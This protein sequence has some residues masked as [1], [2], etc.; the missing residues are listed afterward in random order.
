MRPIT[1]LRVRFAILAG[2][3]MLLM[4]EAGI[5]VFCKRT[6]LLWNAPVPV[7]QT[8]APYLPGNPYLLWEMVPGERE[9]MGATVKVNKLGFRGPETPIH[10]PSGTKRILIV[11]DS[12]VYGHGVSNEQTFGHLL[13]Q[14]LPSDFEVLNLGAPGYSTEQTLN[15]M[16]MRGWQ[17]S[18]DLLIVAN[19][20]SDN[21]FD[22]FIDKQLISDRT[23]FQESWAAP[24]SEALQHSALYRWLDWNLRLG[25]KAAE[26]QKVGWMLGRAPSGVHRRVD[27]NDYA[28]NLQT[29]VDKAHAQ[30]CHVMFLGLANAVD[31]G[32]NTEGAIAWPLYREVMMDTAK[33]NGAP[34]ADVASHFRE[35]GLPTSSLFLDEM[36]PS[37]EGHALISSLLETAV[38]PWIDGDDFELTA[39]GGAPKRWDDPFSRGEGPP[40]DDTPIAK[41]TLSGK[42]IGAPE[43]IPIQIDLVN[44]DPERDEHANPMLG[45]ARFD[46]VDS[47][48]MPAPSSGIFGLRL[49]LDKE[50]DGPTRGDPM[51]T[52]YDHPIRA[53]GNSIRGVVIDM[54]TEKIKIPTR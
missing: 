39:E 23:A 46:H 43:G 42:V 10:K 37:A 18:P 41:V 3:G 20:W 31:L 6:L 38:E 50:A 14:A 15:L 52:F 9:E 51:V 7:T 17:L 24:V 22:S 8:G 44:L 47:F 33:R 36:H 2:A 32:A 27:I 12:S 34:Y 29:F 4:A 53:D 1:R 45:S 40:I 5:S 19:L 26:V 13:D 21:N 25:P 30:D 49:Y 48:E 11:G 35:S 28:S 54:T 16:E